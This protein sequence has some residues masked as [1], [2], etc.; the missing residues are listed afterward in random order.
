M[1]FS[2]KVI[3]IGGSKP[4]DHRRHMDMHDF[5]PQTQQGTRNPRIAK[6]L[7]DTS[8]CCFLEETNMN[9]LDVGANDGQVIV[10]L[11]CGMV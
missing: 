5:N 11:L 6:L 4:E 3:T 10:W 7:S 8:N 1:G 9:G 2:P